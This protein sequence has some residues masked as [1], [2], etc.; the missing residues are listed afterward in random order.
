MLFLGF[1]ICSLS[2]HAQEPADS[3]IILFGVEDLFYNSPFE[4][5]VFDELEDGNRDYL[6]LITCINPKTTEKEVDVYRRWI[7]DIAGTIRQDR[8][9]RLNEEKKINVINNYVTRNLLVHYDQLS[10]FD[11]L[12]RYGRYNFVAE[13]CLYALIMEEMHIP[14]IIKESS[15]HIYLLV[16]PQTEKIIVE[17]TIPEFRYK[18]FD[19]GMRTGFVSY[20]R[21]NDLID[22]I[23]YRSQTTRDLFEKYFFSQ[24]DFTMKELSGLQYLHKALDDIEARAH[25][26]ACLN[27]QKAYYLNPSLKTQYILLIEYYNF[28]EDAD[29]TSTENLAFFGASPRLIPVGFDPGYF[30]RRFT[31]LTATYLSEKNDVNEYDGVYRYLAGQVHDQQI[32]EGLSFIYYYETGRYFSN[33]GKFALAL[34]NLEKAYDINPSD[35]NMQALFVRTLAEYD[36]TTGSSD[37]I[38]R[39]EYYEEEYEITEGYDIF[40]M[41]LMHTYLQYA[42][43]SFQVED[44]ATGETYLAKFDTLYRNNPDIDIDQYLIGRSYSSAAI[45]Y[46]RKGDIIRSKQ[47]VLK[48]LQFAPDNVELQLKRDSFKD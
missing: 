23:T 16:W 1:G 38:S 40:L 8:F 21:E 35:K 28:I 42:G 19:Y 27:L 25:R 46:F 44:V 2:S 37:L 9:G 36:A 47:L 14:Y 30:L 34:D 39:L 12:Y 10:S 5:K 32:R 41:V 43:E 17:T 26:S 31:D 18:M 24:K 11:D 33:S 15:S 45:Y 48:G 13:A 7:A 4:F 3:G 29:L 20:L 22:E 6:A